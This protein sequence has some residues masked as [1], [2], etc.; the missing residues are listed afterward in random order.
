MTNCTTE[1]LIY[2]L[3]HISVLHSGHAVTAIQFEDGSGAKF[4]YQLDGNS[5]WLFATIVLPVK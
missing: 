5:K 4:N 2:G 1:R 3:T